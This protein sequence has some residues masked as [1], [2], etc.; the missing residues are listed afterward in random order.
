MLV[1]VVYHQMILAVITATK[2]AIWPA[3]APRRV[4]ANVTTATFLATIATKADTFPGT[5]QLATSHVTAAAK[6]VI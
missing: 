1:I 4:S 6:S 2:V 3:I 5:V